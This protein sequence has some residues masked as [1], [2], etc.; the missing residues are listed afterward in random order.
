PHGGEAPRT[1]QDKVSRKHGPSRIPRLR[2]LWHPRSRRGIARRWR[3]WWHYQRPRDPV[4]PVSNTPLQVERELLGWG[5][6]GDGISVLL[7]W[8]RGHIP[9]TPDAARTP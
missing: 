7:I 9:S 5:T 4:R 6:E 1:V 8:V 2:R 3:W